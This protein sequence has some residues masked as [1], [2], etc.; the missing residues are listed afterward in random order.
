MSRTSGT[1][2][3]ILLFATAA[4]CG[5]DGGSGPSDDFTIQV[6]PATQ[7]LFT[8]AP[9]NAVT[10]AVVAR[11]D[12]GQVIGNATP[13]FAS[14]NQ[15]VATVSTGGVVTAA[16]AG[17]TQITATVTIG[18]VS[19]TATSAITVQVAAA[20]ATV[21]APAFDF[22]PQKVDV[23]QG[24]SVTWSI[25]SVHHTID[26]TT[27]GAP[28]DIPELL[29]AS[30]ARTFATSGTFAYRCSIHPAMTGEVRVH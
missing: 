11:D 30:A 28:A 12:A 15:A 6:T 2:A 24:G 18:S 20:A 25:A 5:G 22:T 17:T 23:R 4:A 9:G 29:N 8:V 14:G 27:A 7:S 1:I 19:K 16:G 13:T 21:Q 3:A 10:L 26:F